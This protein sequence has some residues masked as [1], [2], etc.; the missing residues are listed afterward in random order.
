MV[1]LLAFIEILD[2][3]FSKFK[4]HWKNFILPAKTYSIYGETPNM[5][6]ISPSVGSLLVCGQTS[7]TWEDF[8]CMG[9][10]PTYGDTS[11]IWEDFPYKWGCR[12]KL[13]G[14]YPGWP[15]AH[16]CVPKSLNG[17]LLITVHIC[18]HTGFSFHVWEDFPYMGRLPIHGKP[19]HTCEVLYMGR[20]PIDGKSS[21]I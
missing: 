7:H 4:N 8:Q 16:A 5:W 15:S 13:W 6:G 11:H 1:A 17:V 10:L 19:P 14:A 20:L 18:Y 9:G 12:P 2:L 21:H 3:G